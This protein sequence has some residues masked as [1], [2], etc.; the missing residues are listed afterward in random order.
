MKLPQQPGQQG[1]YQQQLQQLGLITSSAQRQALQ[2]QPSQQP[3]TQPRSSVSQPAVSQPA[4]ALTPQPS[5]TPVAGKTPS[6][7]SQSSPAQLTCEQQSCPQCL[8]KTG[9][10]YPKMPCETC[11]W[12]ERRDITWCKQPNLSDVYSPT[13]ALYCTSWANRTENLCAT[14]KM[15]WNELLPA[16][17][18]RLWTC[19]TSPAACKTT[20]DT[21]QV[22]LKLQG[23]FDLPTDG[24]YWKGVTFI[25][26]PGL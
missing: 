6:P 24:K 12:A 23:Y 4:K 1:S 20:I 19:G 8:G 5:A 7:T 13:M 15:E 11:I 10:S 3:Q 2:T 21:I 14:A 17:E 16:Q 22:R 18:V 26:P 25:L 9:G